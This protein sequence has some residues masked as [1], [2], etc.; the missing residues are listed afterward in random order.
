VN[1]VNEKFTEVTISFY[2]TFLLYLESQNKNFLPLKEFYLTLIKN[3]PFW[4]KIQRSTKYIAD[5]HQN[6]M[7]ILDEYEFIG[8]FGYVKN[9]SKNKIYEWNRNVIELIKDGRECSSL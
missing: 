4:K 5:F 6:M 9:I 3:V 2:N 1:L 8:E 7:N